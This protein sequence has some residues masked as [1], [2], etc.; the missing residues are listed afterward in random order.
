[1]KILL[2]TLLGY[3]VVVQLIST[4]KCDEREHVF[5]QRDSS[6]SNDETEISDLTQIDSEANVGEEDDMEETGIDEASS[7]IVES[8]VPFPGNQERTSEDGDAELHVPIRKTRRRRRRRRKRPRTSTHM[9]EEQQDATVETIATPQHKETSEEDYADGVYVRKRPMKRRRRPIN[10]RPVY[11]ELDGENI[12][13]RRKVPIRRPINTTNDDGEIVNTNWDPVTTTEETKW[14]PLKSTTIEN[15]SST[16]L[17]FTITTTPRIT[18]FSPTVQQNYVE[19][20]SKE[21]TIKDSKKPNSTRADMVVVHKRPVSGNLP[22]TSAVLRRRLRPQN[23]A[24]EE[25][26]TAFTTPF[27]TTTTPKPS[28]L[29]IKEDVP[30]SLLPPGFKKLSNEQKT[31]KETTPSSDEYQFDDEALSKM[32]SEQP[33]YQVE[34]LTFKS[35]SIPKV[36][37][38]I[39]TLLKTKTGSLLLSNILNLR[40]MSL[41]QLLQHRERGSSQRH[42]ELLE[43]NETTTSGDEPSSYNPKLL[44]NTKNFTD[45]LIET[46]RLAQKDRNIIGL[47]N[48]QIFVD[49]SI[50]S[51]QTKTTDR[52]VTISKE[53]RGKDK[54]LNEEVME[55]DKLMDSNQSEIIFQHNNEDKRNFEQHMKIDLP[56]T[57]TFISSSN[58][59][60]LKSPRSRTIMETVDREP[61][62]FESLP[63]FSTRSPFITP[64]IP[65]QVL[66]I[67]DTNHIDKYKIDDDKEINE[68]DLV[69]KRFEMRKLPVAVKSAIIASA[70]I[71]AI[72]VLGFFVLLVSCRM[73]QKKRVMRKNSVYC[74]HNIH[75]DP[76]L[77]SS[78]RSTSPVMDKNYHNQYYDGYGSRIDDRVAANRQ[79]YLWRTLRRTFRYD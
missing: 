51:Q 50:S 26:T 46:K 22:L 38:E 57:T 8:H 75:P 12:L 1:M 56:T 28:V 23:N 9:Y 25:V 59:V 65:S 21:T 11:D 69:Y 18:T 31:I 27:T 42:Q 10:R 15:P 48:T 49:K 63:V 36:K 66:F 64:T 53:E 54:I 3:I 72:A 68:E 71:L 35:D 40:N 73:R 32:I 45:Y 67:Q 34:E 39:L 61:R 41:E 24:S 30:L 76:E 37:D 14:K 62:I 29:I 33:K 43:V 77:R 47:S 13:P 20:T 17:K 6:Q 19:E 74:K 5:K 58:G 60:T 70:A 2:W 79:Y 16:T 55:L 78:A 7:D 44:E 4:T 52:Y